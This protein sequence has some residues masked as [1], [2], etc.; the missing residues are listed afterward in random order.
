MIDRSALRGAQSCF[1]GRSS[2][3]LK[4][5]VKA[6]LKESNSLSPMSRH[7]LV[8]YLVGNLLEQLTAHALLINIPILLLI[9]GQFWIIQF[10]T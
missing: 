4:S 1:G 3:S 6:S 2:E 8:F 10:I 9:M 7:L 5:M